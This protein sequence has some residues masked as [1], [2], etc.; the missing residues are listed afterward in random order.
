MDLKSKELG[1]IIIAEWKKKMV[2]IKIYWCQRKILPL[3][4]HIQYKIWTVD[5]ALGIQTGS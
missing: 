3:S 2:G 1:A 4:F 5:I